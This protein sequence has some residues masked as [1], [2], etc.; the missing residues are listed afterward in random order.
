MAVLMGLVGSRL[1][2][3]ISF[4][5]GSET[6]MPETHGYR[7][8]GHALQSISTGFGRWTFGYERGQ[9]CGGGQESEVGFFVRL[10]SSQSI[11][12]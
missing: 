8:G 9:N 1:V 11:G 7:D 3:Q 10:R 6:S 5:V 4:C 2:H 12:Q